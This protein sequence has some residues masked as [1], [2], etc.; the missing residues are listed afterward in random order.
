[1][2]KKGIRDYLIYKAQMFV[3]LYV[4]MF[5]VCMFVCFTFRLSVRQSRKNQMT[6]GDQFWQD[7]SFYPEGGF[8]LVFVIVPFARM[9]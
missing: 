9:P 4:C 1:M 5:Y 2:I 3:C 7:G 6:D 8:K